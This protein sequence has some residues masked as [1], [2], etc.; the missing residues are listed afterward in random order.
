MNHTKRLP[1]SLWVDPPGGGGGSGFGPVQHRGEP[2][3][4]KRGGLR[5]RSKDFSTLSVLGAGIGDTFTNHSY[6]L[7]SRYFG[8]FGRVRR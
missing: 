8:P 6:I 7:L 4:R 3:E 2:S 1:W 5:L